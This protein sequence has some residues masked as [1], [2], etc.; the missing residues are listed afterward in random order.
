MY[1]VKKR[2]THSQRDMGMAQAIFSLF[3]SHTPREI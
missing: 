2:N 3:T 1:L